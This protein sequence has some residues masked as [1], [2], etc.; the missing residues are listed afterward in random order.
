[1]SKRLWPEKI[2]LLIRSLHHMA[3]MFGKPLGKGE[4]GVDIA[5]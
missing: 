1:M 4:L 3:L 2:Q 5:W